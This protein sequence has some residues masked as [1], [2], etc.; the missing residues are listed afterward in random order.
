MARHSGPSVAAVG[1]DE[2]SGDDKKVNIPKV[3]L[4]R[5]LERGMAELQAPAEMLEKRLSGTRGT[6]DSHKSPSDILAEL[7]SK[8]AALIYDLDGSI[9][10]QAELARFCL[11]VK[12]AVRQAYREIGRGGGISGHLIS[13]IGRSHRAAQR[14]IDQH[15][16]LPE[17]DSGGAANDA[18]DDD[19]DDDAA[20]ADD[21]DSDDDKFVL[22]AQREDVDFSVEWMSE[23]IVKH[24]LVAI[25]SLTATLCEQG[26]LDQAENIKRD[27]Y[28][29]L[30]YFVDS[31]K[32]VIDAF[33]QSL[34]ADLDQT[35]N[36]TF[37]S[38]RDQLKQRLNA[39]RPSRNKAHYGEANDGVPR[40]IE[41]A[42]EQLVERLGKMDKREL[43]ED[44]KVDPEIEETGFDARAIF[45]PKKDAF[46]KSREQA[47]KVSDVEPFELSEPEKA[48]L[49]P[50][51]KEERA[52]VNDLLN[53]PTRKHLATALN[54]EF[55][56]GFQ[57]RTAGDITVFLRKMSEEEKAAAEKARQKQE[58]MQAFHRNL[59]EVVKR[60]YFARIV[61]I[62]LDNFKI[63]TD[64]DNESEDGLL[65][66]GQLF[67]M[68][69]ADFQGILDLIASLKGE[70]E[71]T[72]GGFEGMTNS[73]ERMEVTFKDGSNVDQTLA[74]KIVDILEHHPLLRLI[75]IGNNASS[76]LRTTLFDRARIIN[77]LD[78]EDEISIEASKELDFRDLWLTE[79]LKSRYTEANY[80]KDFWPSE[81]EYLQLICGDIDLSSFA[82]A[83]EA[84]DSFSKSGKLQSIADELNQTLHAGHPARNAAAVK[85]A[86]RPILVEKFVD[87][88]AKP[89]KRPAAEA[90]AP[91]LEAR[92][93][94]VSGWVSRL[95]SSKTYIHFHIKWFEAIVRFLE[96]HK[97]ALTPMQ[98]EYWVGILET[99]RAKGGKGGDD[100]V[101]QNITVEDL[102][103]FFREM[104]AITV[105]E[106]GERFIAKLAY[107]VKEIDLQVVHIDNSLEFLGTQKQ[108]I[109]DIDGELATRRDEFGIVTAR[110]ASL[111]AD[112]LVI[113]RDIAA[114]WD[115]DSVP[116]EA[117]EAAKRQ[118]SDDLKRELREKFSLPDKINA[119][120]TRLSDEKSRLEAIVNDPESGHDA[121]FA[122]R[123]KLVRVK[124]ALTAGVDNLIAQS[125]S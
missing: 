59:L 9:S 13:Q 84:L 1:P 122:K 11:E 22:S 77:S 27:N 34:R 29:K 26:F 28:D 24:A 18:A 79:L 90:I 45:L 95:K 68:K 75:D 99:L 55:H 86:I 7:R 47:L 64:F 91:E 8:V 17:G 30:K 3:F 52:D 66:D 44:F 83:V 94:A 92:F 61:R 32:T 58:K 103:K 62:L 113:E 15:F 14:A 36:M 124:E 112:I 6:T 19:S 16:E 40:I 89:D 81:K 39:F 123:E 96:E 56:G 2:G 100:F 20:D 119:D 76:Q 106:N 10:N 118:Q 88:T 43:Y 108:Q 115:G 57:L 63:R 97:P 117:E 31:F 50:K 46:L 73:R 35:F 42:V 110:L 93:K 87:R 48:V 53:N 67:V 69:Q 78:K 25:R 107:R 4:Q 54:Q 114:M 72:F 101:P 105:G 70:I 5:L 121:L 104:P 12:N 23:I 38:F 41:Q 37:G 116:D 21:D 82:T 71:N 98:I 51:W 33:M 120:I 74:G 111:K 49:L 60:E 102:M 80:S 125:Y 85:D 65:K 109:T